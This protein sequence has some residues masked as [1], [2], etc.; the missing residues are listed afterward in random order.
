MTTL[1]VIIVFSVLVIVHEFGHFIAARRI[2]VRVEKF[3]I[4]FGPAIFKKKIKETTFLV[5]AFPLGG[6]VKM[7]GDERTQCE[8][9]SDEYFSK[10][11]GER[12]Q[13]VLAGPLANYLL[14]FLLFWFFAFFTGFASSKAIVGKT[15]NDYPAALAGVQIEDRI[16]AVDSEE[17]K[18]WNHMHSMIKT[19][20]GNVELTIE[21]E[22]RIVMVQSALKVDEV[23]D[24]LG[25]VHNEPRIGILPQV[26]KHKPLAS[27]GAG[28]KTLFSNTIGFLKG[29]GAIILGIVPFKKAA[30]GPIGIYFLTS[31]FAKIGVIAVLRLVAILSLN[32]ALINLFP[33]PVLDGGHIAL[34]TIEKI[35]NKCIS[36]KTEDVLNRI[37]IALLV[38]LM[39]FV[40]YQDIR[41][42]SNI[43]G[44]KEAAAPSSENV[45]EK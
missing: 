11:V 26:I 1:I 5:C 17:V 40:F 15:I 18:D 9:K 7:A 37:G 31:E 32:L 24:N 34:F 8:G 14:A 38:T 22:G 20:E 6:F 35:R 28:A 45:A 39:I 10:S 25:R 43:F 36:N 19:S 29:I 3:A 33:V 23:T 21:R 13:V 4:G 16:I 44:D 41:R 2:G 42:G 27:F 12:I 30:M